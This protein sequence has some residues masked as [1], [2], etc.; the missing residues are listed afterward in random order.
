MNKACQLRRLA[1][2]AVL[3]VLAF[4]RLG[5]RLVDLQVLQFAQLRT[6]AESN[7]VRTDY[8]E[9]RR[10]DIRDI[11][12]N[13][14]A[15]S[16]PAKTI[17]ADP[18]LI[19]NRQVEVTR[20]I[21]P[22]LQ[23]REAQVF[24]LLARRWRTNAAGQVG[25]NRYVVLKRKVPLETWQQVQAAMTN[26]TF[27][28]DEKKL[29]KKEARFYREL[30]QSA[31]FPD[32][33][34]DQIRIYPNQ[35][36][37]AH[38]LGYVGMHENQFNGR[39]ILETV[40]MDGIELVCN[41]HLSGVRGWRVTEKDKRNHE[42]VF[43]REVDVESSDGL[44]VVLTLDAGVQYIV[45][46]ELAE[47]AREHQPDSITCL[48]T[49]PRT[50]E[51]VAMATLPNY[52]P[53]MPGEFP[54]DARRNRVVTDMNE[55]GSTFKVVVVSGALHDNAVRLGDTFFCENGAFP[56]AGRVLHDH[57]RYGNLTVESIIT[58]S[59]NI[60]AAK[61]GIKLGPERMYEHIRN[62]GFGTPT[63]ISLPGEI[64]G[65]VYS[66]KDW[67]KVK[68]AQI[69]MGHGLTVSRLQMA[70]AVSAIAN[71]GVLMRPLVVSRLEDQEGR[72]VAQYAPQPVRQ[73]ISPEAAAQMVK[74]LKTVVTKEGTAYKARL[75]HYTCAG[76]TGTAQK[77]ENGT[78]SNEKYY[79]SFIGFFPAENPELCVSVVMDYPKHGHYG[80]DTCGPVFQRIA[81]RAANYLNIHPDIIEDGD[82][83]DPKLA[84]RKGGALL[85]AAHSRRTAGN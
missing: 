26:L 51:I 50:G 80:G 23:M 42:L 49:R 22:L 66:P 38:V 48:V 15:T 11:R 55:P 19:G 12:G 36:L 79:S 30:R 37:A 28:L 68:L 45:E 63:G 69:P 53:N 13:L 65:L 78:Y 67:E 75:E 33:V 57:H 47:A 82:K 61:I 31:I 8:S 77:P 20:A 17:C 62:F 46:S 5:Y 54:P 70:Y 56:F 76:K 60:G 40:G 32:Q 34:P 10:G 18:S 14:L 39:P 2:L 84:G 16:L 27:G 52:D 74:A 24:E 35:R 44:N 43:L 81:E 6:R 73:V 41:R 83:D 4:G 64:R 9:P 25:T 72:V 7:T 59:S 71:Q 85:S 21:A 29:S 1:I 58:K 3:L